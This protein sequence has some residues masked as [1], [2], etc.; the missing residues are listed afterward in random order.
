MSRLQ[1]DQEFLIPGF[2]GRDFAKSQDPRIFRD[3]ISLK[4]YP[5]ILPQ[6]C[7]YGQISQI[8]WLQ[9]EIFIVAILYLVYFALKYMYFENLSRI[10]ENEGYF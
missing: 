8:I 1:R 9:M 5:G 7:G 3:G 10:Y 6:K 4:F 2:P